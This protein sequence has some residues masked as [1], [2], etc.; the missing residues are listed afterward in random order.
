MT[1]LANAFLQ[2]PN[3]KNARSSRRANCFWRRPATGLHHHT[4]TMVAYAEKRT[5]DHLHRFTAS[6]SN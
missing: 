2:P 5:R 4:G 6:T 3:S 1:E